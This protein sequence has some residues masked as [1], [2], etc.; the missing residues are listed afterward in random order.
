MGDAAF[1]GMSLDDK[2]NGPEIKEAILKAHGGKGIIWE[3]SGILLRK[4]E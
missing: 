4:K 2:L 1:H 3:G